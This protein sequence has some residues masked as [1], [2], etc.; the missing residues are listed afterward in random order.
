LK[1]CT[2]FFITCSA[3]SPFHVSEPPSVVPIT[4]GQSVFDEG[5]FAQATCMVTTGDEP[6][7]ITWSF[8]GTNIN[9]ELG[10]VTQNVGTRTSLLIISSVSHKYNGMYT[11]QVTN[12]AGA[13]ATS[14]ELKVNGSR[15]GK[16]GTG[17]QL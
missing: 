7:K 3:N 13:A 8:H 16:A 17:R 6:L 14:T 15:I 11:C 2:G 5:S 9:S 10:I 12:A 4:F 1:D